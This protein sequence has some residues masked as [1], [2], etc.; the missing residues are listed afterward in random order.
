MAFSISPAAND[1]IQEIKPDQNDTSGGIPLSRHLSPSKVSNPGAVESHVV[2]PSVATV[3]DA[4]KRR[5]PGNFARSINIPNCPSGF[6]SK[7]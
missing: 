6:T 3:Q 7:R 2:S 4:E 1:V 5:N